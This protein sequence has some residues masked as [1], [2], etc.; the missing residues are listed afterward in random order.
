MFDDLIC[1]G[2]TTKQNNSYTQ[3]STHIRSSVKDV[4][5][6]LTAIQKSVEGVFTEYH[7]LHIL[8]E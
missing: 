4:S 2:T 7:R 1:L 5:T 6:S 3:W 8:I